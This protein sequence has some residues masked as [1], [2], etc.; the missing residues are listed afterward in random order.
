MGMFD[1]AK[2]MLDNGARPFLPTNSGDSVSSII[3]LLTSENL[4]QRISSV[5]QVIFQTKKSAWSGNIFSCRLQVTNTDNGSSV[6]TVYDEERGME[7]KRVVD[8]A[9]KTVQCI[10]ILDQIVNQLS[11]M[12]KLPYDVETSAGLIFRVA[13]T[14]SSGF[15]H[16]IQ[17]VDEIEP[18]SKVR[19]YP[20]KTP[21]LHS[22]IENENQLLILVLSRFLGLKFQAVDVSGKSPMKMILD[23]SNFSQ[24]E[25]GF[26]WF[27]IQNGADSFARVDQE[28][29]DILTIA[30]DVPHSVTNHQA[31]LSNTC[32]FFA[33]KGDLEAL[34]VLL[35]KGYS[36]RDW[37]NLS[38][39]YHASKANFPT[40]LD[41]LLKHGANADFK[42]LENKTPLFYALQVE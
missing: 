31:N 32:S 4:S 19:R 24:N 2:L 9:Q 14:H 23:A 17:S 8:S 18:D 12:R 3:S 22:A 36:S 38:A 16:F 39:A 42:D 40:C 33:K 29:E 13:A 6:A 10:W 27:A 25:N 11:K 41:L 26:S 35:S 28:F 1:D 30:K 5:G 7:Y 21:P 34:K 15:D 37:E 20:W